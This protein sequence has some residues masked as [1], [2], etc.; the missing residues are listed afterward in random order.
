MKRVIIAAVVLCGFAYALYAGWLRL[1]ESVET[2]GNSPARIDAPAE[3][4]AVAPEAS[5]A[6]T[7]ALRPPLHQNRLRSLRRLPA[8]RP[9]RRRKRPRSQQLRPPSPIPL[10]IP[11]RRRPTQQATPR[12]Q[13]KRGA[14]FLLVGMAPRRPPR[15]SP[16]AA[17][18]GIGLALQRM[19]HI[20]LSIE[21]PL[22]RFHVTL[23]CASQLARF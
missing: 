13:I 21:L 16:C 23:F 6:A 22:E 3:A 4:P 2:A 20:L 18:A 1:P 5:P 8:Q 17:M 7:L 19:L 10:S 11:K 15:S 12:R 9:K 14:F